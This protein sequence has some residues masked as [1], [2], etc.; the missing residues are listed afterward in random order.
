MS[1]NSSPYSNYSKYL[2]NVFI[3]VYFW[4]RI[5]IDHLLC[6]V[7]SIKSLFNSLPLPSPLKTKQNNK[8]LLSEESRLFVCGIYHY[9]NLSDCFPKAH[10][11][12]CFSVGG[13][14]QVLSHVDTSAIP[15]T[16]QETGSSVH[17][18]L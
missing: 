18:I 9:L 14:V 16:V 11:L 17:G 4:T 6:L 10:Y 1:S 5:L 2:Q 12:M 3:A 7:V 13:G 15:W 8:K